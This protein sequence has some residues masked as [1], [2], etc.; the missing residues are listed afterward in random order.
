MDLVLNNP[1]RLICHKPTNKIFK[2]EISN[3]NFPHK[4]LNINKIPR[5]NKFI[6][7]PPTPSC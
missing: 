6:S 3:S 7:N 2:N 1:Q 4:E 5:A